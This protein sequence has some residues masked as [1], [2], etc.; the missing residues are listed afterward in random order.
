M[1]YPQI[2]LQGSLII[3]ISG[4]KQLMPS[5]FPLNLRLLLLVGYGQAC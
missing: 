5:I 1:G 3:N 4:R 2:R